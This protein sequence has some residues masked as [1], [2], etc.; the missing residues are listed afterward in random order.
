MAKT[1]EEPT[2]KPQRFMLSGKLFITITIVLAVILIASA[3]LDVFSARKE[4]SHVMTQQAEA[5]IAAID[6]G[7]NK[8]VES[9][10]LVEAL[11][12][13]RLLSAARL[14]EEMDFRGVLTESF[15]TLTAEQ[16]NI[17][18]INVFDASGEKKMTSFHGSKN[19]RN[20]PHDLMAAIQTPENDEL[21]MGFRRSQFNQ[22]QRF[23]VAKRRRKG[24]AIVM[25]INANDMLELRKSIG[26]GKLLQDIGATKGIRYIVIQ[27]SSRIVV[28]TAN[29]DSM[30]TM[31]SDPFLAKP[32][33]T[34]EPA[35]RFI[36]FHQQK[37]FEIVQEIYP[38]TGAVIRL[39]M[40]TQHV[41]DAERAAIM[42]ALLSSLLLLVFGA[43]GSSLII[44]SQ[45]YKALKNAYDRI[46]SYTGSI[47]ANMTDSVIA[48]NSSGDITLVNASA[49]TYFAVSANQIRGK[50][51]S[52]EISAICP[53]LKES[54]ASGKSMNYAAENLRT[55][56]GDRIANINV[57]VVRSQEE[58]A[59]AVFAVVKDITDQKRLEEN[60]KRK[61]RITA[62]G[63]LASGVAHEIRNPLNAIG[64]IAQRLKIEF[65][66]QSD[67]EEFQ[68][69]TSTV[70]SETRRINEII[71]QFLQ[72]TRPGE[73]NKQPAN[74]RYLL[75]QTAILISSDAKLKA[76]DVIQNFQE[77]P[78][79]N[80][81]A[82]KLKQAFLNIAQNAIAACSQGDS[83]KI[84]CKQTADS[85]IVVLSDTGHGM[86]QESLNK[87][88]N[89]YY[90]T[91]ESGSGIGLSVVQQIISQHNGVIEV[92]SVENQGT[93]FTIILPK[94]Q[95]A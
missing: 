81:D 95:S 61:D 37:T 40:E 18:R 3:L 28:A 57:N 14:L 34:G 66:P 30:S 65:K 80:V 27:D 32:L 62:M 59:Y 60:L 82:G 11:T 89:L 38:E 94:N 49:E 39:G 31:H 33:S 85:I 74:I 43:V 88:F 6:A 69:L 41:T 22:G 70:V 24:G 56:K 44:S 16:N 54:L 23:A 12:A 4:L 84:S 47:L 77:V 73:L 48:V 78:D 64:M 5:L 58:K 10:N 68:Q 72:F 71:Q 21:V 53:Y 46:E 17:F 9:Y 8:A 35:T 50:Q 75:Q 7:S 67:V 63:H 45:N 1:F 29:V 2:F 26:L 90:T 83:I 79:T 25:N 20:A 93:T 86:S 13:E 55:S 19:V 42:R 51:C 36:D 91:K 87:I 52:V 92:Q 15:L 76:I